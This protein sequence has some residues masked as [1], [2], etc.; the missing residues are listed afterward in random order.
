MTIDL[1]NMSKFEI[2]K[3]VAEK[4]GKVVMELR[5]LQRSF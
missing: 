1:E 3:A 2:N 4:L 5:N